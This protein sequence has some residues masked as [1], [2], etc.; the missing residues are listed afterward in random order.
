MVQCAWA[1][2]KSVEDSDIKNKFLELAKRKA[3]AILMAARKMIELI[4]IFFKK[5]QHTKKINLH[6]LNSYNHEFIFLFL[7]KKINAAAKIMRDIALGI[8]Q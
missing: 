1:F 4:F 3:K 8:I 6:P 7:L 5:S 2:V